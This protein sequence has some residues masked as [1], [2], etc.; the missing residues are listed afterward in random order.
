MNLYQIEAKVRG[1]APELAT[2]GLYGVVAGNKS[3]ALEQVLG[4]YPNL[5]HPQIELSV[6]LLRDGHGKEG[7]NE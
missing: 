1:L 5:F 4:S 3:E 6:S 7:E 2:L